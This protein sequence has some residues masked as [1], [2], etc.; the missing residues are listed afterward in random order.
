MRK[1]SF[2]CLLYVLM[3]FHTFACKESSMTYDELAMSASAVYVGGIMSI[4]I[5]DLQI[6]DLNV[7]L[8]YPNVVN[9]NDRVIKMNVHQ[10]LSGEKLETINVTLNWCQGKDIKLGKMGILYQLENGWYLKHDDFAISEATAI[11]PTQSYKN[12]SKIAS[13]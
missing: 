12:F 11:L 5:P 8:H 9:R 1:L 7:D 3:T 6:D 4:A 10:T 2:I 13:H